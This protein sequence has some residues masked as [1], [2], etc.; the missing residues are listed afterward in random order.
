MD[1]RHA[2]VEF[3]NASLSE[4]EIR[5]YIARSRAEG[6]F[7]AIGFQSAIEQVRQATRAAV[8][9]GALGPIAKNLVG[10]PFDLLAGFQEIRIEPS[11]K[12]DWDGDEVF[13]SSVEYASLVP[14]NLGHAIGLSPV[15]L[16]A[17]GSC[18]HSDVCV[19]SRNEATVDV[20]S[21]ATL[22]QVELRLKQVAQYLAGVA[23]TSDSRVLLAMASGLS[24]RES[25]VLLTLHE[26]GDGVFVPIRS[27]ARCWPQIPTDNAIDQVIKD[28]ERKTGLKIIRHRKTAKS[29]RGFSLKF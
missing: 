14:G 12:V 23:S 3:Q 17:I 26:A 10:E 28:V 16:C 20:A 29:E 11:P 7:E 6:L 1:I 13:Q 2:F 9:L 27:L 22:E 4:S 24:E 25:Q 5:A 8:D 15:F 19:A 21:I 18:P